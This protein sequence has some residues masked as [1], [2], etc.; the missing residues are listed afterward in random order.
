MTFD[1]SCLTSDRKQSKIVDAK[2]HREY[3]YSF[4]EFHIGKIAID[5]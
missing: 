2:F 3:V 5:R 1:W 4:P